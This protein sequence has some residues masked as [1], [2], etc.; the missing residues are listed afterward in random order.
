MGRSYKSRVARQDGL[1]QYVLTHTGNPAVDSR[2][3][4]RRKF[5]T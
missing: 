3:R 2:K 1:Q 4:V 5:F